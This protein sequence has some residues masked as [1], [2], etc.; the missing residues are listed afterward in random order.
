MGVEDERMDEWDQLLI[1]SGYIYCRPHAEWHRPPECAIDQEGHALMSCGCRWSD[2]GEHRA[3]CPA[4]GP[5][6]SEPES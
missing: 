4:Y 5:K 6:P 3:E 2:E 1:D